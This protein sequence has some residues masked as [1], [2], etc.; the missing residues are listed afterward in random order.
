MKDAKFAFA[1]NST[2][3]W[4]L[5]LICFVHMDAVANH[6]FVCMC[7]LNKKVASMGTSVR[8]WGTRVNGELIV[9]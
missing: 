8:R 9:D 7:V 3:T 6:D 1:E 5:F 4:S 2:T